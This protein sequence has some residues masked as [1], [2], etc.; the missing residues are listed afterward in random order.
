M[1][2][3]IA[4]RESKDERKT[5]IHCGEIRAE[6]DI[7][8]LKDTFVET[9]EYDSILEGK[10]HPI[11]VGR[12]GSGKSAIAWKLG[13]IWERKTEDT[14]IKITPEGYDMLSLRG[15]GTTFGEEFGIIKEG[16]KVMWKLALL[17][18]ILCKHKRNER[19]N[20]D[21]MKWEKRGKDLWA[22]MENV[23]KEIDKMR[24][25][26]GEKIAKLARESNLRETEE[27]IDRITNV[28]YKNT[29]IIID[30]VDEGYLPD[31][32]G[33]G[34]ITGLVN[35]CRDLN[36]SLGKVQFVIFIRDNLYRAVVE[37]DVDYGKN[38]EGSALHLHWEENRLFWF[39]T[40]RIRRVAN[41][42]IEQ[43]VKVWNTIV[44]KNGGLEGR[45]G[46]KKVLKYTLNRPRDILGLLNGMLMR[47]KEMGRKITN[48]DLREVA[49]QIGQGRLRDLKNEYKLWFPMIDEYIEIFR[50]QPPKLKVEEVI[51][52]LERIERE[53]EDPEIRRERAISASTGQE[54]LEML[55]S[56]G[57][58]GIAMDEK[59]PFVYCYDGRAQEKMRVRDWTLVHPAYWT[60]LDCQNGID[61]DIEQIYD[62]YEIVAT[63]YAVKL[64][65]RRIQEIIDGVEDIPVGTE[66][67]KQFENWCEKTVKVC[68]PKGLTNITNNEQ[69]GG[70]KRRDIIAR[71]TGGTN[72]WQRIATHYN[73]SQVVFEVKNT[74]RIEHGDYTQIASYIG[75]RTP[76][77][78]IGFLI[79]REP[80]E[81]LKGDRDVKWIRDL[82]SIEG[83]LII[84]LTC[85]KLCKILEKLKLAQRK[86]TVDMQIGKL[87]DDYERLYIEGRTK[88]SETRRRRKENRSK[89]MRQSTTQR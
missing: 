72:A 2:D 51:V 10:M 49:G 26:Y 67:W 44:E 21:I 85:G 34:I 80:D 4:N 69:R 18:E 47:S 3:K 73:A 35:A 60:A 75:R 27:Q 81:P 23:R 68:F 39:I 16:W 89:R 54:A 46:F 25:S 31:N 32:V 65:E 20:E 12:R 64:R 71:N 30:S 79:T 50:D 52:E 29:R 17:M 70:S 9:P 53:S 43:D 76:Y 66:G 24:D 28:K 33:T 22:R 82:Y 19:N 63:D 7:E 58:I 37:N 86:D 88:N 61:I 1:T 55:F 84:K 56:I 15:S 11:I 78:K 6:S 48:D 87:L 74:E 62:E 83:K 40:R 8:M 57:F 59:E 38:L 5:I 45:E 77:G 42:A 13:E 36:S 41:I 14:V